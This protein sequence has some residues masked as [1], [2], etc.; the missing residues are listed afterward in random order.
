MNYDQMMPTFPGQ[1]TPLPPPPPGLLGQMQQIDPQRQGLLAAAFQGLQASGPSR[2]PTSLGQ[3]IGQAGQAGMQAQ[4]EGQNDQLRQSQ[5]GMQQQ[6]F[7]MQQQMQ[8]LQYMQHMEALK[9]AQQQEQAISAFAQT[10]PADKQAIFRANPSAYIQEMNKKYTVG[11]NLVGSTGQPVFTAPPKPTLQ[12]IP[13]DGRP[14]VTRK[15]WLTPGQTDGAQVGGLKVPEILSPEVQNAKVDVATRSAAPGL[16]LTRRGQNMADSRARD[17]NDVAA[18]NRVDSAVQSLRKEFNDLPEVKNYR[19]VVPVIN[20]AAQAPDT[21]AGD[22]QM[23]YTIG[24]IFDP[25]SVVRE[26][27]LKLVGDA[28]TVMQKFEGELR[29]LTQ[30]KGRLTPETRKALM[31]SAMTRVN[32]LKSAHDAQLGTYQRTAKSRMLPADQIFTEM[33]AVDAQGGWTVVR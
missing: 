8:Q 29:T 22:I 2:M 18:G 5:F 17:A 11:D 1:G 14:G 25:N 28:A 4:R 15:V 6:Q 10:L 24:K 3:I 31:D 23:A 13:V 16:E 20:S 7:G 27:E 19:S 30:G 21:R 32:A 9:K 12:E 33:P 26:G